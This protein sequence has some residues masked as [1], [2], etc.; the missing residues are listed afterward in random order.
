MFIHD[1]NPIAIPLNFIK[2]GY[3]IRYYGIIYALA[4]LFAYWFLHNQKKFLKLNQEQTDS[5]FMYILIGNIIGAR[6]LDFIF[7]NP[8][9]LIYNPLRVLMIWQGGLS[10]HGGLIG[11]V[12]AIYLF[13]KKHKISIYKVTDTIVIPASLALFFGRIAN[14][15][16]A[17]LIGR[18]TSVPWAVNFNGEQNSVGQLIGRHPSQLYEAIKNLVIFTTLILIKSNEDKKNSYKPGF[19]TWLFIGMYG[20][21]RLITNFWREDTLTFFGILSTGQTLS[22]IMVLVAS[23]F[24][25][26]YKNI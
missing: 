8:S 2:E 5:L 10:F 11:I 14:F 17:E 25:I 20:I 24:L 19:R 23:Y 6:L 21:L 12:L 4:F 9:E 22:L 26:K 15:I 13:S 1:I 18:I 7:Y 3:G 16:N